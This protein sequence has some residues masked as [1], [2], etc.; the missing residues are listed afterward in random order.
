MTELSQTRGLTGRVNSFSGL[1]VLLLFC[2]AGLFAYA[3]L[4]T[5][6]ELWYYW[7]EGYNWQF[8]VPI[9]FVYMLWDRKD[10][11]VGLSREP[12]ILSGAVLLAAGCGLLVIGQ[13]SSTHSLREASIIVNVFG[14][15]LLLFGTKYVRKLFWPLIYLVLMT[16]LTSDLLEYLRYPLKLLSATIAADALQLAGYAVFRDGTFLQLPHITLEVADSCSGLN[17]MVS[18]IALGIPIAFTFLNI[19]WK[20]L[21]IIFLSIFLG[22]VMNWIRVF[23]ISTWH[24]GS[25]KESIHG[26]YG[27]YELPFIF[28]VGV[29]IT[30]VVAVALSEKKS[31]KSDTSHEVTA[32]A[33]TG[34]ATSQNATRAS[35]VA[36]FLLAVTA[37]YLNTWKAKVISLENGLTD[38][39]MEIAGFQG[40]PLDRLEKPFYTGIAHSELLAKYTN[41]AGEIA[42]VYIGYFHSQNQQQELVD[43]RY[44]WLHEDAESFVMP[45]SSLTLKRSRLPYQ[46]RNVVVFFSYDINGRNIIDPRMAKLVSLFDA[47]VSRRSNGAIIMVIFDDDMQDLSVDELAFL[48]Q[49]MEQ[50]AVRVSGR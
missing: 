49:V 16:S 39:P 46:G 1:Q 12:S 26:P 45:S 50:A 42:R 20:R 29:F 22:L 5:F 30:L 25:A 21:I 28:L 6:K 43:Y 44:N 14:L 19:W 36:I 41:E 18:S 13:L 17:Q 23:L 27:I 31:A 37:L 24:Y 34:K 48:A 33:T 35:I 15:V 4:D 32:G 10:L 38:F 7:I 40:E 3:Y 2:I 11:Y 47:L 8:V 9:A